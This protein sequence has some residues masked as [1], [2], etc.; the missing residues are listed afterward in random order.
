MIEAI[1]HNLSNLANLAG[2]DSRSTF[3]FYVL[4]LFIIQFAISMTLTMLAGGAMVADIFH[5]A[6]NGADE[7]V[8]QQQMMARMGGM[9]RVSM[10]GS[11]LLSLA[12]TAL[13]TASFTRRLHDSGKPGWIAAIAVVLQLVA[14]GLSVGM[15]DD[16][17]NLFATMKLDD[18]KAMQATIAARQS[19]YAF[20]GAVG[21]IPTMMIVIFGIWPST[22]GDNRYGAEP[23][24]L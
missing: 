7:T 16:M 2:R 4:F 23:D 11:M 14:I 22:D 18:P 20:K 5:A 15:V 8:M 17:A 24:H 1:R 19:Q 21:W 10:W 3:W 6:R 12:M 9:M 13:L